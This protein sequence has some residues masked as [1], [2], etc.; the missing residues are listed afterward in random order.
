MEVSCIFAYESIV[1]LSCEYGKK[2]HNMIKV[3]NVSH[4]YQSF[5]DVCM[6][7]YK[8]TIINT[9]YTDVNTVEEDA[10]RIENMAVA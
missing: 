4:K 2:I 3:V 6:T 7:Y 5:I 8:N 10:N 9:L 1:R